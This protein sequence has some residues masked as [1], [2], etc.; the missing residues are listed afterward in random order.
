LAGDQPSTPCGSLGIFGFPLAVCPEEPI[1]RG[2]HLP[3]DFHRGV[4]KSVDELKQAITDYLDNHNG[5]PKPYVWTKTVV[6][7]FQ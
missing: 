2:R 3:A 4:F 6:E 1:G 5:R 7:I